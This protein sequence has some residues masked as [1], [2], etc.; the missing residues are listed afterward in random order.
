MKTGKTN[1]E[2]SL[3]PI[4]LLSLTMGMAWA[5]LAGC[6]GLYEGVRMQNLEHCYHLPYPEQ[7]ECLR[8]NDI[9]YEQYRE[10][11]QQRKP[12]DDNKHMPENDPLLPSNEL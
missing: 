6:R 7:V 5:V 9:T 4:V 8:E 12:G 1:F 3:A 11:R 10:E 2:L